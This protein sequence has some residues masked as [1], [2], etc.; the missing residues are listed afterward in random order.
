MENHK[1]IIS[2]LMTALFIGYASS[3]GACL[4]NCDYQPDLPEWQTFETKHTIIHYQSSEDLKEFNKKLDCFSGGW[5]FMRIFS[6]SDSDNLKKKI[7]KK[8]DTLYEKVREILDMRKRTRKV[9]I[10]IYS[11]KNQL[12]IAYRKINKRSDRSYKDSTS[13]RAWYIHQSKSIYLNVNDLN[14]GM[15]AHEMTHAIVDHYLLV[16][17]PKATAEILA[18]YVDTQACD[19]VR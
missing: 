13:P 5:G 1:I 19:L 2:I 17:P 4:T 14:E 11:N 3:A 9:N 7:R 8:V 16:R 15:L 10:K 18:R 12:K 6:G